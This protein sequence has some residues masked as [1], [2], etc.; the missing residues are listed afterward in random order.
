MATKLLILLGLLAV[1]SLA[2][3]ESVPEQFFYCKEGRSPVPGVYRCDGNRDCRD[4]SDEE[5]CDALLAAHEV[6]LPLNA[7]ATARVQYAKV[8]NDIEVHLCGD[9]NCSVV[10][11]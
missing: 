2:A 11:L 7:S 1:V 3:G 4:G 8:H 5:G 9:K 6:A 10:I